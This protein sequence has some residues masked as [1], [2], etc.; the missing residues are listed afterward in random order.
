[1]IPNVLL[2]NQTYSKVSLPEEKKV[3]HWNLSHHE[4]SLLEQMVFCHLQ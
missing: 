4:A 2:T 1:M 3:D